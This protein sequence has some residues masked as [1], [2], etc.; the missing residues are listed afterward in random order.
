MD[1]NKK[2]ERR[3]LLDAVTDAGRMARMPCQ[4]GVLLRRRRH[5]RQPRVLLAS[6][7]LQGHGVSRRFDEGISPD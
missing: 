7:L 1:I 2:D 3:E 6:L 4:R 5:R